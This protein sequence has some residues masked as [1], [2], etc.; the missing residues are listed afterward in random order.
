MGPGV[1]NAGRASRASEPDMNASVAGSST[2]AA[3][4]LQTPRDKA[5]SAAR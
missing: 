2:I 3:L 1:A 4:G 5:A